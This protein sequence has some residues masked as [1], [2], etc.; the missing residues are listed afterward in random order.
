MYK[1]DEYVFKAIKAGANGYL[2]K[3]VTLDELLAAIRSVAKGEAVIDPAIAEKVLD[4]FRPKKGKKEKGDEKISVKD[5][6]ILSLIAQG[7]SNQ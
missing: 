6:E 5:K 3:E 7:L 2:L 1:R 4:E